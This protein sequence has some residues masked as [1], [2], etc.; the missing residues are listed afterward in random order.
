MA[1]GFIAGSRS[2]DMPIVFRTLARGP[3]K[4]KSLW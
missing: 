2:A 4:I 1:I 3:Y